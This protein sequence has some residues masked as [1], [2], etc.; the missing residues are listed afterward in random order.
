MCVSTFC[1]I[2][3]NLEYSKTNLALFKSGNVSNHDTECSIQIC[4][5]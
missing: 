4:T 2:V 5:R 1:I 3:Q